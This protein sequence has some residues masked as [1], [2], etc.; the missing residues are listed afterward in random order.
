MFSFDEQGL[1]KAV[2]TWSS[3]ENKALVQFVLFHGPEDV[4]PSHSKNSKFWSEAAL[5]I[6]RAGRSTAKR[7]G[8]A[9]LYHNMLVYSDINNI[10]TGT[11]H[12][13]G[14]CRLRV[15]SKYPMQFATPKLAEEYYF[16][17]T[18]TSEEMDVSTCTGH[19]DA[20]TQTESY[21][22]AASRTLDS[23]HSIKSAVSQLGEFTRLEIISEMFGA[24]AHSQGVSVSNDFLQLLLQAAHHLKNCNRINVVY[25]L[26]KV[27]GTM[28]LDKTD[29]L[30]PAKRMPMGL[31]EY[32]VQFFSAKNLTKVS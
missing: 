11:S 23:T 14:A 25:G 24:Y 3:E 30:M 2:E 16:G 22:P 26:A 9:N 5:F 6:Q 28:R 31:V 7:T 8:S 27:I 15:I 10:I 21:L 13:A 18:N 32:L 4:W 19:V 17:R 20:S 29:S 1:G 12:T